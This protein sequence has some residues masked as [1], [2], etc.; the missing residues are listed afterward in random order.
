MAK[1]KKRLNELCESCLNSCKQSIEVAIVSCD[2]YTPQLE[3]KF[4]KVSAPAKPKTKK[5]PRRK[6]L[7]K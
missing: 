7:K 1:D 3:L 6:P 4:K 5:P 2:R